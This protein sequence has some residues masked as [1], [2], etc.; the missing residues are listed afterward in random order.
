MFIFSYILG[1]FS[2]PICGP[3]STSCIKKAEGD[4]I[5]R[6]ANASDTSRCN[7]LPPCYSLVY[8][9]EIT[10]GDLDYDKLDTKICKL[11]NGRPRNDINS[12]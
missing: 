2:S 12:M 1:G 8:S 10:S 6:E 11:V 5:L 7:C 9:T 3:G 4:L